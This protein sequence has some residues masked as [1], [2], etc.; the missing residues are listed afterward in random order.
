VLI[1]H[2]DVR[3]VAVIGVPDPDLDETLLALLVLA[4]P[5]DPAKPA[6]VCRTELAGY[7]CPRT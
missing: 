6:A 3:E 5:P 7:K 4:G 1:R 2:P